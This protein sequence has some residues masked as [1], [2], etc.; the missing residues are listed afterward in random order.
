[1]NYSN[2]TSSLNTSDYYD[3]YY[4]PHNASTCIMGE[5]KTVTSVVVPSLYITAYYLCWA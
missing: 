1:M 2:P 3:D 4:Y 5:I